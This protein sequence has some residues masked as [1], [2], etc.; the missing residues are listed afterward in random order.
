MSSKIWGIN[1]TKFNR[2][3]HEHSTLVKDFVTEKFFFVLLAI[4]IYH[5]V[6]KNLQYPFVV[7]AN[8]WFEVRNRVVVHSLRYRK[9]SPFQ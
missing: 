8:F 4:S 5:H 6:N 1:T 7:N 9:I 2:L 3:K